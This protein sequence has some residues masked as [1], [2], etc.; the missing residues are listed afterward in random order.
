MQLS[1]SSRQ[2]SGIPR[3]LEAEDEAILSSPSEVREN[4]DRR[5]IGDRVEKLE[6]SNLPRSAGFISQS[7]IYIRINDLETIQVH[8]KFSPV[9]QCVQ[10][11]PT[12]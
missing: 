9:I 4:G 2:W 1:V 11:R 8:H 10:V 3:D 6:R 12:P 7:Y 5:E